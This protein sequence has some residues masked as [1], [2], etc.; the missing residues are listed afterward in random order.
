MRPALKSSNVKLSPGLEQYKNVDFLSPE[1]PSLVG[2]IAFMFSLQI[3][4]GVKKNNPWQN[5]GFP[6]RLAPS[7]VLGVFFFDLFQV[8]CYPVP[9]GLIDIRETITSSK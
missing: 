4:L 1:A 7:P 3:Y 5:Q 2:G 9:N 6:Y 8:L